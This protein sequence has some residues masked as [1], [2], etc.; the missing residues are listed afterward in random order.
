MSGINIL[1]LS[2]LH[3]SSKRLSAT[4]RKLI[5][6]IVAQTADMDDF[7]RDFDVDYTRYLTYIDNK[8]M[9]KGE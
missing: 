8:I 6:D 9:N 4:S 3:I 2:D 5:Q 7:I 1:H